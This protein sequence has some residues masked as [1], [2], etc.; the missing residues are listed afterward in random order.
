MV[1]KVQ[2]TVMVDVLTDSAVG[3]G[4]DIRI[5]VCGNDCGDCSRFYCVDRSSH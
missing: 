4:I 3:V 5:V 2:A 1:K